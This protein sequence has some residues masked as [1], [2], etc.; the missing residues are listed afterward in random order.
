MGF[1]NLIRIKEKN[2]RKKNKK[3]LE[4]VFYTHGFFDGVV[5]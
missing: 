3:K 4:W 1:M 2:L 5:L